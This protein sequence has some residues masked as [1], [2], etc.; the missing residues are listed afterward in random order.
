MSFKENL[1]KKIKINRL[2]RKVLAT[3]GSVGSG[4]KIDKDTM[5]T[6][7]EI[8]LY[9][10]KS[11][12]TRGLEL[13]FTDEEAEKKNILVLDNELPIYNTTI[14]DVII[15][16]NPLAKEILYPPNIFKIL[17]DKDVIVSK[18]EDSLEIV[19][20]ECLDM[21][22][23]KCTRSDIEEIYKDT[24]HA[25]ERNSLDGVLEGLSLFEEILEFSDPPPSMKINHYTII[26]ENVKREDGETVYGPAVIYDPTNNSIKLFNGQV[27]NTDLEKI[28]FFHNVA[29]GK[30]KAEKEGAAVFQFL[31]AKA[32]NKL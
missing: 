6:L 18:R 9:F 14:E 21:L 4:K 13:Y 16:K 20:Q 8:G 15:R 12:R 11:K 30:E 27:R 5:R 17:I 19:R 28:D 10:R 2:A 24:L 25:F 29:A 1:L 3:L 22:D 7:L 23:L 31:K 32:I 26:G